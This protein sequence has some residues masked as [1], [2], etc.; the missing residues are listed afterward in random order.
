[1]FN[2]AIDWGYLDRNPAKGV[3]LFSEKD[4]MIEQILSPE[5][6]IKLLENCAPHLRPIV[7]T[8]LLTGMRRGE[9]LNLRWPQ[10]DFKRRVIRVEKTK[11]KKI[12]YIPMNEE[13]FNTLSQINLT[14]DGNEHV[15]LYRG[16]P[17]K[18]VK[19]AF[20][21]AVDDA[22]IKGLRF[23]D[24]RHTFATRLIERGVDLITVKELLGH[25]SVVVTQRYTHSNSDQKMNA[26]QRLSQKGEK[27]HEFVPN[28]STKIEDGR[29]NAF[30]SVN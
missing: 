20:K 23:H 13:L 12:R 1:M 10:V 9:I 26:V 7:L 16:N 2:L 19:R 29:L 24:L 18:D 28:L 15:F 4:N 22:K 8:A 30:F 27:P 3:R 11:S 6:E 17:I 21:D 14:V 5:E 25:H